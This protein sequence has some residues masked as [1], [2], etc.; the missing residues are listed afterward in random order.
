MLSIAKSALQT[1]QSALNVTG[2]NIAN[3]TTPGY[4][5]QRIALAAETP[6]RTPDGTIGRGVTDQGIFA[7][8][9]RFLDASY[10]RETG[11]FQHADTLRDMMGRVEQV[12]GEPSDNGLA[13]SIDAF[14]GSFSDLANDPASLSARSAVQQAGQQLVRQI[15]TIDSRIDEVN[16]TVIDTFR[17]TV[18][19]VNSIAQ[20]VAT[21]NQQIVVSG[22]PNRTAPDLQDARGKLLDQLAGYGSVRVIEHDN[23]SVGVVFGDTLLVDGSQQQTLDVRT[24][25]GGGLFAGVVGEARNLTPIAGSLAALSELAGQALPS[26]RSELDRLTSALVSSVN[27]IHASGTTPGGATNTNFFDPAGVTANSFALAAPIAANAANIAAGTTSASGD[28]AVALRLAGLRTTPIAALNSSTAGEFYVSLVSSVGSIVRDATQESDA[29][30]ALANGTATRRSSATG[31]ST[32]E[33]MVD[34]I[35]HQQAFA[36]ASRLVKVADDLMQTLLTMV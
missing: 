6:L 1:Q 28:N 8:R 10:R 2:H 13:A 19:Q 36:A 29:S 34:L 11:V 12:F 3:A 5:R 26:V 15:G 20:Q 9:N 22:G 23:G 14:F 27:A 33:E 32:D 31:V 30:E 21:L 16:Q 35:V 25:V 17:D 4:T 24:P 7:T 18:T